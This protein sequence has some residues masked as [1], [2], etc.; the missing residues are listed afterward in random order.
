MRMRP[1][2][3]LALLW[4][5]VAISRAIADD[6]PTNLS[7]AQAAV[8]ANLRTP[9][10]KAYDEQLGTE[11][12]P[13]YMGTVHQCKQTSGDSASFW[14]LMKLDQDGS[15][16]EVLLYPSTKLGVCAREALLKGKF[17]PPPRAAYWVSIYLKMAH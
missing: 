1:A 2:W 15:V 9:Q 4:C 17:S 12:P 16:K 8:E 6:K 7:D 3:T 14:I 11:F 10:G 13:K 5:L